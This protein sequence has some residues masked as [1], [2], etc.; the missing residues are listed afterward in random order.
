MTNQNPT[1]LPE[2]QSPIIKI[3]RSKSFDSFDSS[4][5]FMY[6]KDIPIDEEDPRSLSI[7]DLDLRSV[8]L[9]TMLGGG[10][11]EIVGEEKL[12]RLKE[13]GYIRL[14]AKVLSAL[15]KDKSRIPESWKRESGNGSRTIVFFD[16]TVFR[17]PQSG[18][19]FVYGLLWV[20]EEWLLP[21]L[22]LG[23]KFRD[24]NPSA[25]LRTS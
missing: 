4:F 2:D 20:G 24:S 19:R 17:N 10:E 22:W 23:D 5:N 14:D 12:N 7:T 11:R 8:C 13:A 15:W 6:M 25:V 3:D 18:I 21:C 1:T 16:G 9:E